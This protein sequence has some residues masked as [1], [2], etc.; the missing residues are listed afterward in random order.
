MQQYLNFLQTI[1]DQGVE[2]HDRTGVGTL[3]V[4][5]LEMRFDL[6]KGFPL[7]TTKK[8]HTKSIIHELLWFLQGSTNVSSLQEHG[9]TIWDEWADEQGNLGPVYGKQWRSWVGS[10]GQ[11]I[12]QMQRLVR[13]I[14]DNP[15]SRRLIVNAWNV[16]ELDQMA[17]P[18]CHAFFQFYVANG[19]LSCKLTQRSADAFL[20]VP[21]NIASYAFLI[22]MIAQQTDLSV[23]ELIWSGGDC[24]IYTN[25]LDA[26]NQQLSR[27]PRELPTL[28]LLRRPQSLFDYKY[29]D[30]FIENY[31]PHARIQAPIA[32]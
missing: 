11:V 7:L 26:V 15:N 9:V 30:F 32:V 19:R 25:H 29:E 21:F 22:T 10:D 4:F 12:D 5:G 14:K 2:K 28:K 13:Q 6:S 27:E 20:G 1:L 3:S 24:H 17:L 31:H 23:G 8:V 16:A 18:P